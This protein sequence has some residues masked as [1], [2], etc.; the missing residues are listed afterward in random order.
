MSAATSTRDRGYP[1]FSEGEL[2]RRFGLVRELMA[3][4]DVAALLLHGGPSATGPVHYLS[5][6]LPIRPTWMLFALDGPSTLFLHFHNHVP[7][8]RALGVVEDVRC[9][10]PSAPGAVAE[11]LRRR[12]LDRARVGVTGLATSIPHGQF[13]ELRRLL[14]EVGFRDLGRALDQIRWVRS[15][16]ELAWLRRSAELTDRACELLEA[17]IR[18]GLTEHDLVNTIHEAFLPS[19]G[20]AGLHFLAATSMTEPDRFVPWQFPTARTLRRGDV[21]IT[22]ITVRWWG[23]GAQIHRPFAV[24][25]EPTARY[26]ELFE[27]AHECF[28]RVRDTLR[29]GA[30]SKDVVA[31]AEVIAERGYT[32]FDSVVH[33][34]GGRNPE[35]GIASSVH[36]LEPWTFR[37]NQ[38]MVVQPN[39]ITPDHR[40]GLQLG[41]AV[42]VADGGAE[43]LHR[44]PFKFPVCE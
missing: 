35:L 13:E 15:E 32:V 40:A 34:E 37:E 28:R 1:R 36:T 41:A 23:Y 6:Y 7:N 14:P 3:R 19:G 16:E 30:T 8:A 22:E 9:Y 27:V 18:P 42:R 29:P 44:Y 2:R 33:G 25:A 12:G 10:W 4:E 21:V 43:P 31:A 38:V 11:E 20:Q 26:R 17:R 24:A 39:P 5:G